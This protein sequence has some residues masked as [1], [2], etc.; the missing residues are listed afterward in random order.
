[1]NRGS[2]SPF[3]ILLIEPFTAIGS[4]RSKA[5]SRPVNPYRVWAEIDLDAFSHNLTAISQ[6]AGHGVGTML[7][8]KADA[9][10]HGAVSLAH[11]AV[12]CGVAGFGVGTSAEAL[13][14]RLSGIQHP[15]LILGTVVDGEVPALLEHGIEIGLHSTDR[16][17]R[18]QIHGHKAEQ[19]ARVHVNIDT[20]MGRLGVGPSKAIEL[21]EAISSA[22]NLE[23]A[24]VMTHISSSEGALDPRTS[25]QVRLFN[26][27]LAEARSRGLTLGKVHI[28]NSASLFTGIS[29][30]HDL[31][32]PGISAYGILPGDLPGAEDLKAILSLKS[33]IV[34]LKDVANGSGVGY[35]STWRATGDHRIATIPVGYNDGVSWKLS[36]RGEVLVRGQ[37]APIVGRVSMDYTTIDVTHIPD[38]AVEDVVTILGEDGDDRINVEEI[39]RIAET[40]PYEITCAVG[41]RVQRIY[42]GGE[43]LMVTPQAPGIARAAPSK[44]VRSESAAPTSLDEAEVRT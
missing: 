31:V 41:R 12:R 39:A 33:Q 21:L 44:E 29:P 4:S 20:G 35:G 25:E 22:S 7:V 34:F 14:L 19:I 38:V 11:H 17:E 23:L 2:P 10:G 3:K 32:R 15:I 30:L 8:V 24:G 27:T 13:E 1:M 36:D 9:Y 42:T 26:E 28:A 43:D 16:A 6:R 40:I 5:Y 18:L 37:R